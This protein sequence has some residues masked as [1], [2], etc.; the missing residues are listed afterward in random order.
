M[1]HNAEHQTC[2]ILAFKAKINASFSTIKQRKWNH[3]ILITGVAPGMAYQMSGVS[4]AT[5]GT[6]WL[7]H[8]ASCVRAFSTLR[9]LL[10][11]SHVPTV[12]RWPSWSCG[13]GPNTSKEVEFQRLCL[14]LVLFLLKAREGLLQVVAWVVWGWQWVLPLRGTNLPGTLTALMLRSQWRCPG[15][16]LDLLGVYQLYTLGLPLM[17]RCQLLHRWV[18]GHCQG[19]KI[20]EVWG[21][22]KNC[23]IITPTNTT[24]YRPTL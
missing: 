23:A 1:K 24:L 15:N 17:I 21:G 22:V 20:S 12:G 6:L 2:H 19:L 4:S 7:R 11:M 14:D 16:V 9:W 18:H 5:L 10:W 3:S 8:C 13:P